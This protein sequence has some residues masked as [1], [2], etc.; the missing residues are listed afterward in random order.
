MTMIKIIIKIV[1]ISLLFSG[2]TSTSS[3]VDNTTDVKQFAHLPMVQQPSVSPDGKHIAVMVSNGDTYDVAVTPFGKQD[4]ITVATLKEGEARI[5]WIEWINNERLL[6]SSSFVENI[7]G[8]NFKIGRLYAVNRD[9]SNFIEIKRRAQKDDSLA[10]FRDNDNV[11]SYL[12]DDPRH[13]ILQGYNQRESYP[14]PYK[15]N[16]YD[17]TFE[18]LLVNR[19]EVS[20]WYTDSKGQVVLGLAYDDRNPLLR[21]FWYLEKNSSEWKKLKSFEVTKEAYFNPVG[22]DSERQL[23]YVLSAH[24]IGRVSLYTFNIKTGKYVDLIYTNPKYDV[25]SIIEKDD[26]IIGVTYFDDYLKKHYFDEVDNKQSQLISNTFKQLETYIVSRSKSKQKLLVYG[27]KD[28]IPGR[29]FLID[30]EKGK[31]TPWYSEYPYLEGKGLAK[32]EN[33][34][35]QTEDGLTIHGYL[36]RPLNSSG[37]VPLIVFPHGGPSSRDYKYFDYAVQFFASQG[38]AVLQP[39]FRGS[40][41]Y[42]TAFEASGYGQ[43]GLKMQDDVMAAVDWAVAQPGIDGNKMCA[44]GASYGG[45]VALTAAF[46]TPERFRCFVSIAGVSD[47]NSL[48]ENDSPFDIL[49]ALRSRMIGNYNNPADAKRMREN[50]IIHHVQNVKRP[51]LLIHGNIDTRV[52]IAQSEDLYDALKKAGKPVEFITLDYGSHFLD[53]EPSRL[54]AFS[55]IQKFLDESL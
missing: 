13:I 29:Y 33:F 34:S 17:N 18:K 5:E 32:K 50:S 46:K 31:A 11:L 4:L 41:G 47:L 49:S 10:R 2:F 26:E 37:K 9:G 44:V 7:A 20:S 24:K 3:A 28:N 23:A 16:V 52:N 55:T 27:V 36:T 40:S 43:W 15:V 53:R 14:V 19:Y 48:V 25:N 45:Y 22:F 30:L 42:G 38:Y 8:K 51:I 12:D 6:I 35:I 39:N 54:K 21:T 1:A